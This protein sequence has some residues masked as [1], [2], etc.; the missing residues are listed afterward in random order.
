MPY[1]KRNKTLDSST[2]REIHID[3][4]TITIERKDVSNFPM[5]WSLKL[6]EHQ[7]ENLPYSGEGRSKSDKIVEKSTFP[8]FIILFYE[9][10]VENNKVIDEKTFFSFYIKKYFDEYSDEEIVIKDY[11][12]KR[13][14]GLRGKKINKENLRSRFLRTYPSLIRDFHF[15]LMCFENEDLKSAEYSLHTD[16]AGLDICVKYKNKI[17]YISLFTNTK[18]ANKFK[19][20][21]ERRHAHGYININEIIRT[22]DIHNENEYLQKGQF[23]LYLPK[24]LTLCIEEMEEMISNRN[25]Y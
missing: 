16:Y 18:R 21:K 23:K 1:Q 3:R 7:I 25:A 19:E 17:F 14:F 10:L 22:V 5:K 8:P 9:Y 2:L 12:S 13:F 11:F 20:E 6:F 4:E 15:L 24:H